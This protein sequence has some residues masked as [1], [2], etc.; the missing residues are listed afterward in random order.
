MIKVKDGKSQREKILELFEKYPEIKGDVHKV[1]IYYWYLYEGVE[2]G[3]IA[4]FGRTSSKATS[5]EG[6]ARVYRKIVNGR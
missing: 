2:F 6:I 4:T 5:Y 1:V 3:D